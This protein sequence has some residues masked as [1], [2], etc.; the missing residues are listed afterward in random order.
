MIDLIYYGGE[1]GR[2]ETL[3]FAEIYYNIGNKLVSN[4]PKEINELAKSSS[5]NYL[6][7]IGCPTKLEMGLPLQVRDNEIATF[8]HY[9]LETSFFVPTEPLTSYRIYT[10]DLESYRAEESERDQ[11]VQIV[12][13][14]F[15][16]ARKRYLDLGGIDE[17]LAGHFEIY[18]SLMNRQ[19]GGTNMVYSS[20]VIACQPNKSKDISSLNL[21]G[22][23]FIKDYADICRRLGK[24]VRDLPVSE[25]LDDF[26]PGELVNLAKAYEGKSVAIF[27][28]GERK[29]LSEDI[30]MA[31]CPGVPCHFHLGCGNN[32]I[33]TSYIRFWDSI[34]K[35][36]SPDCI[37]DI[38][39][40]LAPSRSEG[41]LFRYPFTNFGK[42]ELLA[43][44]L[45]AYMGFSEIR[46]YEDNLL[47]DDELFELIKILK[48]NNIRVVRNIEC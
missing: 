18:L 44:Q 35:Y 3:Q 2:E 38:D 22:C 29:A 40:I 46:L 32:T 7:F 12:N 28:G 19:K 34:D 43:I 9:E 10:S 16:I 17:V 41:Y 4:D 36:R 37:A 21:I 25:R 24:E 6:L 20:P 30:I 15:L 14:V 27:I 42:K 11:E 8:K 5:S 47:V 1:T 26:G 48:A 39:I 23:R 45:A 31:L 13:Q 33:L